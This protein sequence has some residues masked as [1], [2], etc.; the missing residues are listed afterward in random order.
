MTIPS[1]APATSASTELNLVGGDTLQANAWHCGTYVKSCSWQSSAKLLGYHPARARWIRNT[2]EIEA[3]G[4]RA[5]IT[6]GKVIN[7]EIIEKKRSLIKTRWTNRKHWISWSSGKVKP[8]WTTLFVST[9]SS[10]TAAHRIFGRPGPVT[11]Y[12]GAF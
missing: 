12:A 2:A 9:R 1:S 5:K 10:A 11:A 8:S 4:F 6:L 3:H 7:V